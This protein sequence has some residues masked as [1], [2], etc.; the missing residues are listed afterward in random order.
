MQ[1]LLSLEEPY[2]FSSD[3]LIAYPITISVLKQMHETVSI[4]IKLRLK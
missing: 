2:F 1:V 3:N 4:R